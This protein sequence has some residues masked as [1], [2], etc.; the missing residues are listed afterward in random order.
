MCRQNFRTIFQLFFR[1]QVEKRP[2]IGNFHNFWTDGLQRTI[3]WYPKNAPRVMKFFWGIT[4]SPLKEFWPMVHTSL[5]YYGNATSSKTIFGLIFFH[6]LTFVQN[7]GHLKC[8]DLEEILHGSS[9]WCEVP[10]IKILSKSV[11]NKG[12]NDIIFFS[13]ILEKNFFLLNLG[14]L[15]FFGHSMFFP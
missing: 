12:G 3:M 14:T 15:N 5:P 1:L 2:K 6:F 11:N 10:P 8:S 9:A 13:T 7:F 4:N